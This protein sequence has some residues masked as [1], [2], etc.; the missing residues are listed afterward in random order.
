[1]PPLSERLA[2]TWTYL[3]RHRARFVTGIA[4]LLARDTIAIAIPL[5]IRKAVNLLTDSHNAKGA[6]W[7]AAGIV[8]AALPKAGLQAFARLRMMYVSRDAEYEMRN[9]LFRHLMSLDSGFYSRMRTGDLM[10]HATNDLNAVKL[11][12]GP[13]LVNLFELAVTFPIAVVVMA[14]VDWRLTIVALLP[15][16]FAI[17]QMTW[18]GRRVHDR[19]EAIQ[20]Q[21]SD[22]SAVVEQHIAGVRSVRAFAQETA[23]VRRFGR[24]NDRYFEANRLL[25]IYLSMGDPLLWFLMS[26][27]TL[28]VLWYGGTEIFAF[29][30][31]RRQLRDVHDLYGHV[32]APGIRSRTS[33]E[34]HAAWPRLARTVGSA[35]R[36]PSFD[37]RARCASPSFYGAGGRD[38]LGERVR[39]ARERGRFAL[40]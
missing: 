12:L 28:A 22:M 20:A 27:A 18:F 3:R 19:T 34:F 9:D 4:G 1:M 25:G 2:F 10:A 8:F 36:S 26:L 38:S 24:M 29:P 6:A 14:L 23:E 21:F 37:R 11:M 15:V 5:L 40:G 16:P 13:G 35:V 33:S 31:K 32:D 17:V 39:P 7:I 30:L